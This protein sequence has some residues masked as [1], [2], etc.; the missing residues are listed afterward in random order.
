MKEPVICFGQQPNGFF[1][2]RFFYAKVRTAHELQKRIG[3]KII[4]F[5]HDSDADPRETVTIL[6]DRQTG[7]E[8]RLNFEQANKIQKK[9]SPLY[10]KKI[11]AGWQE[12]TLRVLPQYVNSKLA[13]LFARIREETVAD[14]CLNAY[15]KLG[16]M[17]DIKLVRSGDSAFRK[18]AEPPVDY[19]A[20]V[21]YDGKLYG[22]DLK[23][24]NS[25]C[26]KE[27]Q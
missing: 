18:M 20:D 8:A 11:A 24:E 6:I 17:S 1:P 26:T 19:F 7:K 25:Y 27:R 15:D 10:A 22:P 2:K 14:F 13:D 9:Y 12:K 16:L 4:F 23:T 21:Q 3:G 5:Y